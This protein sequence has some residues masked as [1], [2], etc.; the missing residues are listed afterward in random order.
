MSYFVYILR[1][2]DGTLYTGSTDD[3]ARRFAVHQS[4]KGAKYTR[5][6]APLTLVYSEEL[7]NRGAALRREAEIK[8]KSR[9]EKLL[10]LSDFSAEQPLDLT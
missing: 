3:V 8:G 4:G 2:G 6:R 10:L 1:C 5:G 9:K 7:E